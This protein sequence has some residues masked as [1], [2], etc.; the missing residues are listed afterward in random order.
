ML[1]SIGSGNF[2]ASTLNS[3]FAC[4]DKSLSPKKKCSKSSLFKMFAHFFVIVLNDVHSHF[5]TDAS[6]KRI[7]IKLIVFVKCHEA[8]DVTWIQKE[9][10]QLATMCFHCPC[11][12]SLRK[13]PLNP[14]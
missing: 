12:Q 10:S 14:G 5:V 7:A 1:N 2:N 6:D 13:E 8:A 4:V 9:I 11:V 3:F